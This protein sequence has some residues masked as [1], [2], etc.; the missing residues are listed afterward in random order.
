[1]SPEQVLGAVEKG[2]RVQT[3]LVETGQSY[4]GV[5]GR[6]GTKLWRIREEPAAAAG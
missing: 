2:Q 4:G 5:D 1:M 6:D 3:L